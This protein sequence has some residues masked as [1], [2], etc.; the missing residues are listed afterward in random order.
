MKNYVVIK[1]ITGRSGQVLRKV[2]SSKTDEPRRN[3]NYEQINYK[4]KNYKK[5]KHLEIKQHV[6]K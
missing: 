5:D 1:W 4:E 2:Q 3:R 6:S